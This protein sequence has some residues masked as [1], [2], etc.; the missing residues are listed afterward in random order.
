[1]VQGIGEASI[2]VVAEQDEGRILF[3]GML[4]VLPRYLTW[5]CQRLRNDFF[6]SMHNLQPCVTRERMLGIVGLYRGDGIP[7]RP[8]ALPNALDSS[9]PG[10]IPELISP[11]PLSGNKY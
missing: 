8:H 4:S 9:Q 5:Y 11:M 2:R 7:T 1:M 10:K 3:Q 6:L